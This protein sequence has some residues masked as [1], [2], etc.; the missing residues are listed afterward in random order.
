MKL[1]L[2]I[3]VILLVLAVIAVW[4]YTLIRIS[5]K[6]RQPVMRPCGKFFCPRKWSECE[7]CS[8]NPKN[9]KENPV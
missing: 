7:Y 2:I 3:T 9:T 6:P 5:A 8:E 4:A 1:L